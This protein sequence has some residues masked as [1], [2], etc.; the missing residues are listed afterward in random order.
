MKSKFDRSEKLREILRAAHREREQ[1]EV[2]GRWQQQTLRRIRHLAATGRPVTAAGLLEDYFWRW[3]TAGGLVTAIL[4]VA[5]L[6]FQ[7]IPD[8]DLW[9]FLLYE[10]ET[11]TMLQGFLY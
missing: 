3:F 11:L 9:S 4:T 2:D 5:L 1:G 8:V 6:N 10:N 7:F